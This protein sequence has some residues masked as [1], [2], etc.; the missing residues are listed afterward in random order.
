MA[1]Q[2]ELAIKRDTFGIT[3]TKCAIQMTLFND[4]WSDLDYLMFGG[5]SDIHLS[6][7]KTE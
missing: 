6:L 2:V 3:G 1:S 4:D 5:V 7:D